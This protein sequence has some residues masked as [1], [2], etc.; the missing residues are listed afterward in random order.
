MEEAGVQGVGGGKECGNR[1]VKFPARVVGRETGLAFGRGKMQAGELVPHVPGF[2][3]P[4]GTEAT[5]RPSFR[6]TAHT[7]SRP[8]LGPHIWI[9]DQRKK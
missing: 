3:S 6:P 1:S 2:Y 4:G 5:R 9:W 8:V 7:P